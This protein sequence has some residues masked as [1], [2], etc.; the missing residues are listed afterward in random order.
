MERPS[1][2]MAVIRL[3]RWWRYATPSQRFEAL[4]ASIRGETE[5]PH[6]EALH[7]AI[8]YAELQA[9]RERLASDEAQDGAAAGA[10]A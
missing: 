6:L 2:S 8:I 10:A 1:E 9:A 4:K 7:I 3:A 5:A